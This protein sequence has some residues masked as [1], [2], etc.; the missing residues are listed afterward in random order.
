MAR[1]VFASAAYL[2]DVAPFVE[3]ANRIVDRGHEVTFLAPSGFHKLL[4]GE[5]FE[6]ATYPLDF[7][8]AGMRA[9]STHERLMQ[10]PWINQLRL[11]RY[12]M[13]RGLAA[14]PSAGRKA[15]LNVLSGADVLV[16]HPTFGAATVPVAEH[17]R[18]PVVVGQLFPMMM[19]TTAWTPP[20]PI[21]NHRLGPRTNRFAWRAFAFG[22]GLALHDRTVNRYR[23]SLGLARLRGTALLS[24]TAARR[25]VVLVSRHYFGDE[26]DDWPHWRLVGFSS[27][28]GPSGE[29]IDARVGEFIDAGDAPVL[30]CLGTSA[31]TGAA[32]TFA[33][34]AHGLGQRGLRPLLFVGDE[35]NLA[36]VRDAPGAFKFVPVPAVVGRCA[37]AVVSGALGTLAAA[38][39]AGVPVV[40]LP[41]LFDQL[42]HGRRVEQLGV[43]IMVTRPTKVAD[44]VARLL[45]DPSYSERARA[46]AGK[47]S[48][49]D[50]AAALVDATEA[51]I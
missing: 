15:L 41:Q 29:P 1:V 36:H 49:E 40:V 17:L 31:A 14:D 43:G 18:V 42:W 30:V 5:R 25:T 34:I 24:W 9:D 21:Q 33:A 16:T 11:T 20:V 37:A 4:E 2:G 28:S 44:A 46:L 8:P 32:Q 10:H 47:L 48:T 6:L 39:T 50:G 38:L 51:T 23:R 19:P 22:S 27:W 12:W 35:S 13:R 45:D 7:S 3:P 26:P